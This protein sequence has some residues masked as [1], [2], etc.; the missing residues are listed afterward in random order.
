MNRE[1]LLD[2]VA[3]LKEVP[4]ERFDMDSWKC[5]TA[6]CAV[7]HYC[8]ARPDCGLSLSQDDEP[9]TKD[10]FGFPIVGFAAV[11]EHFDI[12]FVEA[13][14]LFDADEYPDPDHVT[15]AHVIDRI[16]DFVAD[17]GAA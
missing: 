17:G 7:G 13:H 6:G 15:R 3:V 14:Y 8:L 5:G 1:R 10:S 16:E 9:V 2:V 11:A 4:D 12:G